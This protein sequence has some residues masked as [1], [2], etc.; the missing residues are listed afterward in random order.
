MNLIYSHSYASARSFALHNDLLP[1]DWKWIHDAEVVRHNP[2]ADVFKVQ[3]WESNPNREKIDLALK[4]AAESHRLGVL[5]EVGSS[6]AA[7][8]M[9]N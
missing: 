1:G 5:V 7:L 4:R 2:R 3:R 6:T 8:G 9:G